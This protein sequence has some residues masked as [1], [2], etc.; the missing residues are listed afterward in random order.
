MTRQ[1][2][3]AEDVVEFIKPFLPESYDAEPLRFMLKAQF[4]LERADTIRELKMLVNE[5]L[6]KRFK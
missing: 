2:H 4:E 3:K 6:D 5:L 1:L